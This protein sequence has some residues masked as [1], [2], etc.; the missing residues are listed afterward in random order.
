MSNK[1]GKVLILF[2]ERSAVSSS[3]FVRDKTVA[4]YTCKSGLRG[5]I[6]CWRRMRGKDEYYRRCS[7]KDEIVHITESCKDHKFRLD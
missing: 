1:H 7:I 4:C 6:R 2:D 5:P 3:I